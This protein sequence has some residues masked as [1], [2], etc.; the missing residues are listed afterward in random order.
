MDLWI[1]SQDKEIL[2]K[3]TCVDIM[4]IGDGYSNIFLNE[5]FPDLI[6]GTYTK[7][8]ALEIISEIQNLLMSQD[9]LL[10]LADVLDYEC[11]EGIYNHIKDKGWVLVCDNKNE[12]VEYIAPTT[13]VYE[14][15]Q[16]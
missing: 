6:V 1:K 2:C 11:A 15:P 13:I 12:S 4:H 3:T 10:I 9:K 5:K 7:E 16:E 8:R 14:M